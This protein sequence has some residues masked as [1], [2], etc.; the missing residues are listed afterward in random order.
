MHVAEYGRELW[1]ERAGQLAFADLLR[2]AEEQVAREQEAAGRAREWLVCD[3]TPLTTLFYSHVMFGCADPA[4]EA[5]A[6]RPYDVVVLCQPDFP[7]V[8]DGTRQDETFRARQHR[9]YEAE[10]ARRRIPFHRR[11][12][13]SD[14]AHR[15]G[16]GVLAAC[17]GARTVTKRPGRT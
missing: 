16:D 6:G 1:E 7:F 10:L 14:P 8:Q 3:T 4:L 12:R 5:L 11:G 2:I 9:W 17:R 15:R 13:R